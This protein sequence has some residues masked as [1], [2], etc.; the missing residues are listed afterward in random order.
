MELRMGIGTVPIAGEAPSATLRAVS[1]GGSV[2][3]DYAKM[4]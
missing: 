1:D 3:L 4:E 2:P